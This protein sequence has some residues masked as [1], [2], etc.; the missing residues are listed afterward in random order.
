MRASDGTRV[1]DPPPV[2]WRARIPAVRAALPDVSWTAVDQ[3]FS[4]VSN[5]VIS[6]AV[7]RAGGASAL[8]EFQ[9]AFAIWVVVMGFLRQLVA[10]PY[11]ALQRGAEG[12]KRWVL[13]ATLVYAA[14]LSVAVALAGVL[15]DAPH[16]TAVGF[17]LIPLCVEEIGRYVFFRRGQPRLAALLDGVWVAWSVAMWPV[18]VGGGS[19]TAVLAWGSGGLAGAGVAVLLLRW[20]PKSPPASYTWWQ[21]NLSNL[22]GYLT[23]AGMAFTIGTQGAVLGIAWL[24]GTGDLGRLRSVLILLGP[25]TLLRTAVGFYAVPR[26]ARYDTPPTKRHAD[27]LSAGLAC[28]TL[29]LLAPLVVLRDP[30]FSL[31]FGG[32]IDASLGLLVA[33]SVATVLET[34]AA[35]YLILLRARR[36]GRQYFGAYSM[37]YL[38]GG[39]LIL[40]AAVLDGLALVGWMYTIQAAGLIF[41]VRLFYGTVSSAAQTGQS[42]SRPEPR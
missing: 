6:L 25:I 22:G 5:V 2:G 20:L 18:V 41:L 26:V 36:A 24:L 32:Q 17:M 40:A 33:L 11:L 35:G 16:V 14:P 27:L 3:V 34:G 1:S 23:A 12:A 9:V 30:L 42:P 7:A 29:L 38:G 10:E 28:G 39:L 21:R 19:R 13:G 37:T 31:L 15:L 4:A 8:G